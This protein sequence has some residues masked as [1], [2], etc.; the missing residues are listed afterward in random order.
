MI[1]T[2]SFLKHLVHVPL[3]Q[4]I[5]STFSTHPVTIQ[6]FCCDTT[7]IILT[8]RNK[9]SDHCCRIWRA[10]VDIGCQHTICCSLYPFVVFASIWIPC[11]FRNFHF[12]CLTYGY[13]DSHMCFDGR[14]SS[15]DEY[16]DIFK[17]KEL[18]L[19]S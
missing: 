19:P 1:W 12:V 9:L 15:K 18:A 16:F 7:G 4:T 13:W 14:F 10:L 2:L 3:F 6:S 11:L 5:L 8:R 17:N